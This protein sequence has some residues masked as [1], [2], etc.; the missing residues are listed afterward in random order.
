[1]RALLNNCGQIEEMVSRIYRLLAA[2][3]E[4][5]AEVRTTFARLATDEVDHCRQLDQA[6]QVPELQRLG[7][8]RI[9]WAKVEEA[10]LQ[11]RGLLRGGTDV[12]TG[13][14]RE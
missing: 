9:A 10:L 3:P 1:M 5:S 7:V 8:T 12:R 13:R 14:R 11:A 4:Y 2:R 6:L